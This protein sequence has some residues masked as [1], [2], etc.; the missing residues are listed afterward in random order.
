MSV[1][2]PTAR[3][4]IA[5]LESLGF[6]K[7]ITGGNYGRVWAATPILAIINADEGTA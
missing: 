7:E 5:R 4:Y 2:D 3:N 1:K 6:L